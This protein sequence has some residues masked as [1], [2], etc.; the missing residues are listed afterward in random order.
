MSHLFSQATLEKSKVMVF[1][2]PSR[3]ESMILN[4]QPQEEIKLSEL[5]S[6]ILNKIVYVDWP[7]LCPA[8]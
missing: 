3:Y 8:K 4:I 5:A 6:Q 1:E 2:Q 7:F